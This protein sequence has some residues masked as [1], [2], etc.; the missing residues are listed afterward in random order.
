MTDENK[1]RIAAAVIGG[2]ILSGGFSVV[3]KIAECDYEVEYK[4]EVICVDEQ[5][6]ELLEAQLP[7][8][9]K[10]GGVRFNEVK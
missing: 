3:D 2:S 5:V 4:D 7:V 10:F 6:K 9:A 1:K 8:A